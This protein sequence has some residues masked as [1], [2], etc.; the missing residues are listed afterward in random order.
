ML[1]LLIVGAGPAGLY[2]A[3]R[4]SAA[5]FSVLVVE[6][7]PSPARKFLM[8]GRG[9]LNLTHSEDL[10]DFKHRYREAE[11]FLAPM[12]DA[13][14]PDDLRRWCQDL[15]EDTF[16]GSS[17]RVFPNKM[18]ASPLLRALLRR[19]EQN[20]VSLQTRWTWNGI[21]CEGTSRF[22]NESGAVHEIRA[23]TTLLALGGASWPRLGSNAAWIQ[24]LEAHGI[25]IRPFRPANCG[26]Q[27]PWSR[28]LTDRFAGTPLKRI[29][30]TLG[31]RTVLGEA[32]LS[33]QGIEGGAVYALSAEIR[34]NLEKTG[35]ADLR[36]DLKPQMPLEKLITRL[37]AGR[38]SNPCRIF[39]ARRPGCPPPKSPF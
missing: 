25:E 24:A 11:D 7:M 35:N 22:V 39:Y 31:D 26:F 6:R 30:L 15:G 34:N 20:K 14:S 16:I 33:E 13:F 4:V 10:K 28:H 27:V 38:E 8:A 17:G 12:L 19:L 2:A 3:D 18:K 36:A 23:R 9:G 1:D 21:S 29:R 5:G 37:S 32:L